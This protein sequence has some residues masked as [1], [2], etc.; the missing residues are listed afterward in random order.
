MADYSVVGNYLRPFWNRYVSYDWKFGLALILLIC[1]T[2]FIL[3]MRAN[4]TGSYQVI[5]AVMVVSALGHRHVPGE[6]AVLLF[7]TIH[8]FPAGGHPLPC[9]L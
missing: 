2:R 3:L 8:R 9:R 5:A 7:Q 6:P 1:V 4:V